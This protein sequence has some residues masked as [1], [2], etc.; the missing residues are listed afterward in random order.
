[1]VNT[2]LPDSISDIGSQCNMQK[3]EISRLR[4]RRHFRTVLR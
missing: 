4:E 3:L 1:M 2:L